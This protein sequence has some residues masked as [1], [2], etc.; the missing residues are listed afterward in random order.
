MSKDLRM[1][2]ISGWQLCA[3]QL[4]QSEEKSPDRGDKD[5]NEIK[6]LKKY[7]R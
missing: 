4:K 2:I 5:S 7:T 6:G 3:A 1:G